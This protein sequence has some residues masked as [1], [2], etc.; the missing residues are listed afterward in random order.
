HGKHQS[1]DLLQAEAEKCGFP[2]LLK[3]VAGGGGKGMRVV[4]NMAEFDDALAAAQRE[5][6]NAFGNPDMLIERYLTQPRHVE[7]QVFCDQSGNG[8]HL[9]ER[10]CSVKRRDKKVLEEAP[11]P[12]L[13]DDTPKAMG[14]AA[15]RAAAPIN[16]VAAATVESLYDL[17]GSFFFMEMNTRLQVE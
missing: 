16:C 8:I 4:E 5:A 1:P 14:E 7:I 3:A 9:A 17:D 6:K 11:A 10:D 12:G 2:L 15:A 13:S